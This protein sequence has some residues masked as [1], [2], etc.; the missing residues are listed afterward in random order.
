MSGRRD[1]DERDE[2]STFRHAP[3][4]EQQRCQRPFVK[5]TGETLEKT[6]STRRSESFGRRNERTKMF[7]GG[8]YSNEDVHRVFG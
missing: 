4:V 8:L 3:G 2:N 6:Q 1:Q 7:I 5:I